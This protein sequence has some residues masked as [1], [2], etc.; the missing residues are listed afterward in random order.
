MLTEARRRANDKYIK[1]MAHISFTVSKEMREVIKE[2]ADNL[3]MSVNGYL[4][5][6]VQ[7]D[8]KRVE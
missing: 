4:L 1:S 6:L 8:L 2:R 3:N 5:K 7:E